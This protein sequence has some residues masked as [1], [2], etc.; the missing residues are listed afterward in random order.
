MNNLKIEIQSR[1]HIIQLLRQTSVSAYRREVSWGISGLCRLIGYQTDNENDTGINSV[2]ESIK[3]N[4]DNRGSLCTNKD[5][6]P[7]LATFATSGQGKTE[8]CMQL[9]K[10]EKLHEGLDGIRELLAIHISF[11]QITCYDPDIDTSPVN[12]I[13]SRVIQALIGLQTSSKYSFA[14]FSHYNTLFEL[15][16]DVREGLRNPDFPIYDNEFGILLCVD[17]TLKI[18]PPELKKFL[19]ALGELQQKSLSVSIPTFALFTGLHFGKIFRDFRTE[20]G[21]SLALVPLCMISSHSMVSIESRIYEDLI[22]MLRL[23]NNSDEHFMSYELRRI[24]KW[25]A[26]MIGHN[27]RALEF[28]LKRLYSIL[29]SGE[30]INKYK[31]LNVNLESRSILSDSCGYHANPKYYIPTDQWNDGSLARK[32]MYASFTGIMSAVDWTNESMY[33]LC[34]NIFCKLAYE[35]DNENEDNIWWPED[36]DLIEAEKYGIIYIKKRNEDALQDVQ[37]RVSLPYLFLASE[38]FC[39]KHFLVSGNDFI[40]G[41]INEGSTEAMLPLILAN[42]G[43]AL[44]GIVCSLPTAF[45]YIMIYLELFRISVFLRHRES[46]DRLSLQDI[47]PNSIVKGYSADDDDDINLSAWIL[48]ESTT[49]TPLDRLQLTKSEKKTNKDKNPA[50]WLIEKQLDLDISSNRVALIE[51]LQS[52]SRAIEYVARHFTINDSNG[53][54]KPTLWLASMKLRD[55]SSVN[56][57]VGFINEIHDIARL[58]SL[59]CDCQYFAVLYCCWS[60]NKILQYIPSLP[61]GSIIIPAETLRRVLRPFGGGYLDLIIEEKSLR[62]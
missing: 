36:D 38:K 11:N 17:E 27:F 8:L 60:T 55:S 6:V 48:E 46:N 19:N 13:A 37:P 18:P 59:P 24:V 53:D 15:F 47:L 61:D 33:K 28:S 52:Q 26:L 34:V 54:D 44:H 62:L 57:I 39:N 14:L 29:F 56:S 7:L 43:I 9:V 25:M 4:W 50:L 12:S 2:K 16:D 23:C 58:S 10:D 22:N 49:I 51:S 42:I 32:Y 1:E 45:E 5:N 3:D 31:A 21:R 30:M 41:R 20:S 35:Y 40:L